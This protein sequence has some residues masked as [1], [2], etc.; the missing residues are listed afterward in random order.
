VL[1]WGADDGTCGVQLRGLYSNELQ[2]LV[3]IEARFRWLV[4]KA[5]AL[6]LGQELIWVKRLPLLN[7]LYTLSRQ[8]RSILLPVAREMY[9]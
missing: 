4:G 5:R 6:A 9:K 1:S 7:M 2:D 8:K 3:V